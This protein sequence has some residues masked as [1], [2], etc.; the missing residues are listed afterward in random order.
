[1]KITFEPGAANVFLPYT[2]DGREGYVAFSTTML[3]PGD[4][5]EPEYEEL[6]SSYFDLFSLWF[7]KSQ[8]G[9]LVIPK[10]GYVINRGSFLTISTARF[11]KDLDRH[12]KECVD[13][14]PPIGGEEVDDTMV[15]EPQYRIGSLRIYKFQADAV[16]IGLQQNN[17]VHR[18][19]G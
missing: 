7:V 6:E 3:N 16:F 18:F 12:V 11:M 17:E 14:E 1:M 4:V 8:V 13:Q 5:L 19:L 2:V 10:R 15:L 9:Y